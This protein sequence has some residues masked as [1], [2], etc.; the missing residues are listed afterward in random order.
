MWDPSLK[1]VCPLPTPAEFYLFSWDFK[2]IINAK[3][4]IALVI[5][6]QRNPAREGAQCVLLTQPPPHPWPQAKHLNALVTQGCGKPLEGGTDAALFRIANPAPWQPEFTIC[7]VTQEA[8]RSA[9]FCQGRWFWVL[10]TSCGVPLHPREP[11]LP[12]AQAWSS[13]PTYLWDISTGMIPQC[14]QL[15]SARLGGVTLS[16][17]VSISPCLS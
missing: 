4:G 3:K 10:K 6:V 9:N 1:P 11:V 15:K 13:I 8:H 14:L 17:V 5:I 12:L 16:L 2:D 7:P